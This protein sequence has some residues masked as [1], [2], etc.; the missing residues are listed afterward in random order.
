MKDK[1]NILKRYFSSRPIHL[2]INCTRKNSGQMREAEFFSIN[3]YIRPLTQTHCC[4]LNSDS[5]VKPDALFVTFYIDTKITSR[6]LSK[7]SLM[8]EGRE[9]VQNLNP[10]IL[11]QKINFN[12]IEFEVFCHLEM[13][14]YDEATS[15]ICHKTYVY[16]G[17]QY[18]RFCQKPLTHFSLHKPSKR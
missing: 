12:S 9:L 15:K 1:P 3:S 18:A 2:N 6:T 5:E 4:V 14:K 11:T 10:K 13:T 8:H 16:E 7:M 17:D